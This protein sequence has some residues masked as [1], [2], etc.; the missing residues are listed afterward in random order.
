MSTVKQPTP[1]DSKSIQGAGQASIHAS[2]SGEVCIPNISTAE[3]R[4]RLTFGLVTF[5][6][7]L[8]VLAILM[9]TGVNRL[10]RLPLVLLFWGAASG[11]FQW[12]DQTWV[13]LARVDSVSYTH[14][15]AHETGS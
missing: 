4:K 1:L 13:G 15:R 3:R 12:S 2:A 7:S 5:A 9:A 10:W 11:Y 6:I 8:V 14:L